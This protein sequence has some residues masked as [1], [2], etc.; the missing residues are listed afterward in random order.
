[1]NKSFVVEYPVRLDNMNSV[2]KRNFHYQRIFYQNLFEIM[3]EENIPYRKIILKAHTNLLKEYNT[4]TEIY[5][6]YHKNNIKR[7][8]VY[9][10]KESYTLEEMYF[11]KNGY[12]GWA[13]MANNKDLFDETQNV[14][15]DNAKKF[16]NEFFE[17]YK[18]NG[19]TK[20]EQSNSK[21]K[22]PSKFVLVALQVDNDTVNELAYIQTYDLAKFVLN[23]Y[24]NSEYLVLIKPHPRDS[25]FNISKVGCNNN[26]VIRDSLDYLLPKASAVYTVNS[27]VGFES[28]LYWKKVFT[29]GHNDYHWV[30]TKVKTFDDI[31]SNIG[32]FDVDNDKILKFLYY[33]LNEYVVK[34]NNKDKIRN[35]IVK[36]M[37]EFKT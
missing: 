25:K 6:A 10:I 33:Y 36:A 31:K 28:L 27:G 30:T 2:F 18:K 8:N 19:L 23:A 37:S 29:A 14:N 26:N 35:K 11:D 34:Y 1:M 15:L 3:K 12:S 13:E 24:R 9:S 20:Y 17:I 16:I 32:A 4:A 5:L 7:N 22:L 21:T